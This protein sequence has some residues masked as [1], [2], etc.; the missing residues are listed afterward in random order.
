MNHEGDNLDWKFVPTSSKQLWSGHYKGSI[1]AYDKLCV[2]K[3]EE[4]HSYEAT[5]KYIIN[6]QF[7]TTNIGEFLVLSSF[8]QEETLHI[9]SERLLFIYYVL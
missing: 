7:H 6:I 2:Q 8:L 4:N 9:R 5:V 3:S 1:L